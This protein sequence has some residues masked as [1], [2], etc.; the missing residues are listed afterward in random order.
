MTKSVR[1][2]S[3]EQAFMVMAEPIAVSSVCVNINNH[4]VE[5]VKGKDG[6]ESIHCTDNGVVIKYEDGNLKGYMDC[7]FMYKINK[8]DFVW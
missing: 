5:F 6:I 3:N 8:E 2:T 1:S 7:P 4:M